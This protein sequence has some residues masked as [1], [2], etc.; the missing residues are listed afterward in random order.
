MIFEQYRA[1]FKPEKIPISFGEKNNK[2]VKYFR[3]GIENPHSIPLFEMD[4]DNHSIDDYVIFTIEHGTEN[5]TT[6]DSYILTEKDILE[7]SNLDMKSFNLSLPPYVT[8]DNNKKY[9]SV[10]KY[11]PYLTVNIA[12]EEAN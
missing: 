6:I 8:V 10:H 11:N 2:Q 3:I 12:Y 1:P 7:F 5:E 9:N 4:L